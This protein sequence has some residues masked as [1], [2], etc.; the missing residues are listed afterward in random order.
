MVLVGYPAWRLGNSRFETTRNQHGDLPPFGQNFFDFVPKV[1]FAGRHCPWVRH[2][3]G[4]PRRRQLLD[5]QLHDHGDSAS[6]G[7]SLCWADSPRSLWYG[8]AAAAG[9][10]NSKVKRSCSRPPKS[11]MGPSPRRNLPGAS[12]P[13][14]SVDSSGITAS[15]PSSKQAIRN[16]VMTA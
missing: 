12:S 7:H 9:A 15:I 16:R 13:P 4:Q 14:R 8:C 10:E 5:G 6:R 11:G 1:V 3:H 2:P